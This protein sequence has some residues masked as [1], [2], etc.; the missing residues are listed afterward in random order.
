MQSLVSSSTVV[1]CLRDVTPV[2]PPLRLAERTSDEAAAS[3]RL[4][5]A[6]EIDRLERAYE[7]ALSRGMSAALRADIAAAFDEADTLQHRLL[8]VDRAALGPE[9]NA[10]KVAATVLAPEATSGHLLDA[11]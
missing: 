2:D 5:A 8:K 11:A 7:A 3:K 4:E 6:R 1:A 10:L 9:L